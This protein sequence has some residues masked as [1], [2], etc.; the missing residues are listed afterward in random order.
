MAIRLLFQN[1]SYSLSGSFRR[2]FLAGSS[3]M[4]KLSANWNSL[5]ASSFVENS[6]ASSV[7]SLSTHLSKT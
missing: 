6:D 2:V 7:L 4:Q 3:S 1:R 5:E